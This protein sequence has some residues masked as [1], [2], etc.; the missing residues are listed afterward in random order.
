MDV[1]GQATN[2][3]EQLGVLREAW[4]DYDYF[5][6]HHKPT[7]SSAEDGDRPR[8]IA[9][10]E[11]LDAIVPDL[12]DLGPEVL[13]VSGDHATPSQMAAHSWHPV[14]ALVWAP[15][16]GRDDVER[17][18]ERWCRQGLLGIRPAKDLMVVLLAN[19]G[20]LQ[21]YGA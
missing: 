13:A 14:P 20:R 2:L 6:L 10:I 4:D 8:K 21:K 1:L 12:R 7:D 5:F 3:E 11:D 17:F 18:G 16:S 9:A 15:R 19:A